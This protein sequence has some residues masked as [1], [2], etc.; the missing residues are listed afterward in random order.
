M[1]H[2]HINVLGRYLLAVPDAVT[3]GEMRPP[4]RSD[5]HRGL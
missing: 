3:R 5:R 1:V 4:T 2:D